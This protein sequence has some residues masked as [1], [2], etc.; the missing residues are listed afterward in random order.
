[1]GEGIRRKVCAS[2]QAGAAEIRRKVCTNGQAGAEEIKRKVCANGQAGAGN[3]QRKT[4]ETGGIAKQ[5]GQSSGS[6][7]AA[8]ISSRS[9]FREDWRR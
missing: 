8:R 4:P 6:A 2:G 9:F 1:M 5:L 3:S 7:A